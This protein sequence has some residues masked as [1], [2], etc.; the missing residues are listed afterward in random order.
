[1]DRDKGKGDRRVGKEVDNLPE[2]AIDRFAKE[3]DDED[4]LGEELAAA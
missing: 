2:K 1:M 3:D 4:L